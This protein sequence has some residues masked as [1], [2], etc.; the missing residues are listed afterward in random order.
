VGL[1]VGDWGGVSFY[2]AITTN[3]SVEYERI[4]LGLGKPS[5]NFSAIKQIQRL[6]NSKL[7]Y[8][9]FLKNS[10]A[11]INQRSILPIPA[12]PTRVPWND[13]DLISGSIIE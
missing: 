4:R 5:A 3:H 9:M 6:P 11:P 12:V 2:E 8:F 13:V 1:T 10:I 7:E